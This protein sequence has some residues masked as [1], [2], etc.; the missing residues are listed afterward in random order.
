MRRSQQ[1]FIQMEIII[2]VALRALVAVVDLGSHLV[3]ARR[4]PLSLAL[5]GGLLASS[6]GTPVQISTAA[7]AS[8]KPAA[9]L[10][11]VVKNVKIH[12]DREGIFSGDG[13]MRFFVGIWA[14]KPSGPP[15]CMSSSPNGVPDAMPDSVSRIAEPLARFGKLF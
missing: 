3:R 2:P 14:C 5:V 12:N 1:R 13:E 6:L 10:Q 9:R 15:L 8:N 4:W 11:I 7:E